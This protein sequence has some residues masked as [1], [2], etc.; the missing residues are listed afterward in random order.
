MVNDGATV[1][2]NNLHGR[3]KPRQ[4]GCRPINSR[5]LSRTKPTGG[6]APRQRQLGQGGIPAKIHNNGDPDE[7]RSQITG[8]GLGGGDQGT[9]GGGGVHFYMP[10]VGQQPARTAP[11]GDIAER[12][13]QITNCQDDA[14]IERELDWQ[15]RIKGNYQKSIAFKDQAI[16]QNTFQPFAF[17]KGKSPAVHMVHSVGQNFGLSGLTVNLQGK[18]IGFIGDRGNGCHP[19]PFILPQNKA[20][21]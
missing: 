7:I 12:I 15:G 16:S 11:G 21:T 5:E 17:M 9:I 14:L 8:P 6:G 13:N 1:N 2:S 19:I 18:C 4:P 3:R 10:D 20:W